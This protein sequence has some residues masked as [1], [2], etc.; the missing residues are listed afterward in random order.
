[1]A[2]YKYFMVLPYGNNKGITVYFF[3]D[4][5]SPHSSEKKSKTVNG[6]NPGVMS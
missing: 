6:L 3:V 4:K 2:G 5:P 1:M